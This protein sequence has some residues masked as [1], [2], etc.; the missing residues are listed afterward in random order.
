MTPRRILNGFDPATVTVA[1]VLPVR[2]EA[3]HIAATLD[4]VLAQSFDASRSE[5][6]V[7][8]GASTDKT[9]EI[10]A[11]Y[12]RRHANLRI[13]DNPRRTTPTSLNVGI[14]GTRAEIIVR[15]D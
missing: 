8:D 10:L 12:A 1:V 14:S 6:V 3:D 7:V 13:I 11:A 5:I 2:N 9:P 4:A 15:V